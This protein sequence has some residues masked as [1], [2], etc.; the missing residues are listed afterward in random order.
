[1][2]CARVS[3]LTAFVL[4]TM[5]APAWASAGP[6]VPPSQLPP[7]TYPDSY[8]EQQWITMDDGI[9]LGATLTFPSENGTAAAPGKFPVVLAMT[10]YGREESC[11]CTNP[12]DFATRGFV[13]AEVDVRGTGGSQGNLDGNY[14]S[15]RE[16]QDGYDLVEY[17]GTQPWSTGKVGMDGG[18]YLGIDQYKTAE[19]DPPHLAAIAPVVALADIYNDAYAPGGIVSG[20]FDA[21]YLAVQGGPGLVS[22]NTDPSMLPGT[23]TAKEQQATGTPIALAYLENPF[24][25]AFYQLRNP[26]TEVAKIKVPVFV[27]DGWRDGF[28][29]GDI[30]M[31]QALERRRG[32]PTYLQVNPCTHKGCGGEFA[33][34][35]NPPGVDN[36][37]AEEIEFDQ[38]YL[39]GMNVPEMPRVR[40]YDQVAD[41]Y[42]DT[43]AWP[44]PQSSFEREYLGHGTLS[45]D[46]LG[47]GTITPSRPAAMTARYATDP[48]AGFSMSL[49]EQGTIAAS[50]YVPTD[51]QLEENQGLTLRT[52]V[53]TQ[54]Q[55]LAG[56][57]A[58]HLVA[59]SSATNT[60]W[61]AKISDVAPNGTESIVTEG[62]L[63]AS[64][65]ALAPGSTPEEPLETLT[66]PQ[67][68]TPGRF[69]DFEIAIAPTSYTFAKGDRLQ[70]RLTSNNLPNALPGTLYL[71]PTDP[72][73]PVFTPLSP[74]VNTVRFG[75]SDGTSL[76]LPIYR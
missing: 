54:P 4:L 34:T 29:A 50:P 11:S 35:D 14:F 41:D 53:L 48:A 75:G 72:A 22:P 13:F 44:P 9:K 46:G 43:T 60:D 37:E 64:L 2:S 49:D 32:V 12:S 21:Q 3:L 30:R 74:A 51:Q 67:P 68:L 47:V 17:L 71:D 28:E 73:Q 65:R 66:T 70:I 42:I 63:R 40:L 5:A 31:F 25:D 1:M 27:G 45:I 36:Y 18:S 58:L 23:I 55:T 61:F 19:T 6:Y 59:A 57:I 56:P 52:P 7:A 26:I 39:M 62:Q 10:P 20:S 76:L 24:D 33:P 38:R 15:P 16:A 8:S 69:Y